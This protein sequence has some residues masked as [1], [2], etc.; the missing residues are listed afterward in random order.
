VFE[1]IEPESLAKA[2][3]AWLAIESRS[4]GRGVNIDG[5]TVCGSA[6]AQHDAYHVLSA[7]VRE[8]AITLGELAVE[9]KS[10]EITAIPAYWT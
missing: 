3:N 9:A 4:G 1:R 2:L 5:K 6:N 8:N 10:N 7:W